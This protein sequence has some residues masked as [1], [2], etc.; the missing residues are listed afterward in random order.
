VASLDLRG[1]EWAVLSACDTGIASTGGGEGILGL[2]RAF[3]TAGA[4]TLVIS[5]WP[6]QDEAARE[7]MRALYK[8]RL[9]GG[10]A[11]A[12]AVRSATLDVLRSRRA[13]GLS[14]SPFFWAAFVA[15]GDWD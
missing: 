14:T 4:S 9:S 10:T 2:R 15:T 1:V 5:L 11:T 8:N 13:Q 7:W 6:V 12:Q 3:R